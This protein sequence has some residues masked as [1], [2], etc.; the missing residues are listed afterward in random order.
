MKNDTLWVGGKNG[1]RGV[2]EKVIVASEG[3][4]EARERLP[5]FVPAE[6]KPITENKSS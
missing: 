4:D 1:E 6:S 3:G 5:R 2:G